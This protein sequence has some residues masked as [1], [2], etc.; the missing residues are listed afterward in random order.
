MAVREK[1]G[2]WEEAWERPVQVEEWLKLQRM[3][4]GG[5][6]QHGEAPEGWERLAAWV[7]GAE[8][9]WVGAGGLEREFELER[10]QAEV[11]WVIS[12]EVSWDLAVWG[13]DLEDKHRVIKCFCII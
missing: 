12:S 6:Q 5:P 13:G 10:Q 7:Q 2:S 3:V 8:I 9:V 1:I 11:A 4:S